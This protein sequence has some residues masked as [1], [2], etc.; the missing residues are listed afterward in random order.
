MGRPIFEK[1]SKLLLKYSRNFQVHSTQFVLVNLALSSQLGG[2]VLF[3]LF[4]I[5]VVWIDHVDKFALAFFGGEFFHHDL[6]F[7][8][9]VNGVIFAHVGVFSA[10][11]Y[12]AA[13]ANNNISGV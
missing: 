1:F 8:L 2:R 4:L 10:A 5:P 13:L 12:L 3:E 11:E 9:C 7:D 6:A